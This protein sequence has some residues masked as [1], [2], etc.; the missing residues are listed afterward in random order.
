MGQNVRRF[1]GQQVVVLSSVLASPLTAG[2]THF[3]NRRLLRCDGVA[4]RNL[5]HLAFLLDSVPCSG[6]IRFELDDDDLLCIPKDQAVAAVA[7]VLSDNLIPAAQ[8]PLVAYED[9]YSE[10]IV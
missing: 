3:N 6:I 8:S 7:Q 1:P 10:A 4:V 9:D 5:A 2:L